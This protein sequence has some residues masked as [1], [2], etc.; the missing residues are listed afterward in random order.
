M[1]SSRLGVLGIGLVTEELG[2]GA[3]VAFRYPAA[4]P[5]EFL[6]SK[7]G[8][9]RGEAH[10]AGNPR[11][12]AGRSSTKSGG[13]AAATTDGSES[14][15][16]APQNGSIDLFFDLPAR[17]LSK[18][19]RPKRPL[20]G[21]PLTLNVSGTTFCCRAELF[22]SQ[23]QAPATVGGG[24][25]GGSGNPLVLFS[26]IVALAPVAPV[27]AGGGGEAIQQSPPPHRSAR[28]SVEALGNERHGSDHSSSHNTN[29]G[30]HSHHNHHQH[31]SHAPQ[32]TDEAFATVKRVHA[33]LARLCKVLM[34]EEYRCHY[35]SRQCGRLLRVQREYESRAGPNNGGAATDGETGSGG[36]GGT[37][38]AA[39]GEGKKGETGSAPPGPPPLSPKVKTPVVSQAATKG[40]ESKTSKPTAGASAEGKDRPALTRAQRREHVQNLIEVLLAASPPSNNAATEDDSSSE[41]ELYGNLAREL[42]Q[43]FHCMSSSSTTNGSRGLISGTAGEGIVYINRH[44]A[45]PLEPVDA[46]VTHADF[47][48]RTDDGSG[49]G[50]QPQS[51]LLFPNSSPAEVLRGMAERGGASETTAAA[52]SVAQSLQR[53]LPHILP[54]KTLYEVAWDA[55]LPLAHVLDAAAWLV[56]TE[57]CVA[58]KPV[59]RKNRYVCT[60]GVVAKMAA[61]ALPF[62]QAFG[63][64]SRH[65]V[66]Y[67][68]GGSAGPADGE[69]DSTG[70]RRTGTIGAP[71]IF[72]VVSALTTRDN[73][74]AV[75]S[76]P[77]TLGEAID[78]LCSPDDPASDDT[79]SPLYPRRPASTNNLSLDANLNARG[80]DSSSAEEIVY[81]M[82]CW[83]VAN[84]ILVEASDPSGVVATDNAPSRRGRSAS[85]RDRAP[86]MD[87]LL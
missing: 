61:L 79:L 58:A 85:R 83:L 38:A 3:R 41:G 56:R 68:G 82:A 43:A 34:R 23:N 52:P 74:T 76:A 71:H 70:K 77:P 32:R 69:E 26:V 55:G 60:Q 65:C 13:D 18:L 80:V 36:G 51:A 7:G 47:S 48:H 4:P 29:N 37:K 31:N 9:H 62:W 67:W 57:T 14:S 72:V 28:Q 39:A 44:V 53:L 46:G 1:P 86:T 81:A 33:N 16:D 75:S 30:N 54:R 40:K 78:Y 2:K 59:L 66:F 8:G 45:V 84:G 25:G 19:F 21:Q 10:A 87:D 35:V 6:A 64:R 24:D 22:D 20:C 73:G 49:R 17:V 12:K 27:A 5:P 63:A 11:G 50:V 15:F 42:A